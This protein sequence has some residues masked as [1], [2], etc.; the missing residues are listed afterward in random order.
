[1]GNISI[2]WQL[3]IICV[4]LV[5]VP[6]IILGVL[7]FNTSRQTILDNVEDTL[8]IQCIDWSII[9]QSYYD[10]VQESKRAAKATTEGIINS[11][12]SGVSQVIQSHF[13]ED[14]T[15]VALKEPLL[16]ARKNEKSLLTNIFSVK[17]FNRSSKN[18]DSA[19]KDVREIIDE[20]TSKNI[21][22]ET[23]NT[24][25]S[26]Y[27]KKI[28]AL[29]SKESQNVGELEGAITSTGN[30]LQEEFLKL[31]GELSDERLK[32][33]LSSTVIGETGYVYIIDYKGNYMLSKDRKRDGESVWYVEDPDGEFVIQNVVTKGKILG[34][35][36]IDYHTYLWKEKNEFDYREQ[37][38]AI[39]HIPEKEWIV[40]VVIHPDE[41]IELDL[42]EIK[43]QELK[44][45][46]AKQTFGKT[47]NL[48][49]IKADEEKD[50]FIKDIIEDA[51]TLE[52]GKSRIKHYSGRNS[53]LERQEVLAYSFFEPWEWI[54]VASIYLDEFFEDINAVRNKIILICIIA[55]ILGSS[56]VYFMSSLM[57]GTLSQLVGKMGKVAKGDLDVDMEDV[58][59]LGGKN[60]IAQL[61]NAFKKMTDNLR[62]TTFSKDYVDS[63]IG[64]MNDALFVV[65]SDARIIMINEATCRLIGGTDSEILKYPAG[66]FLISGK[67]DFKIFKEKLFKAG[68]IENLEMGLKNKEGRVIPINISGA[69]LKDPDGSM[70]G[71]ILVA[72]D[73][74]EHKKLL[75]ELSTARK[76][77]EEKVERLEKSDKAM[78]F[79]VEDLN[80]T[81]E[82]LKLARNKLEEKIDEVEKINKELD[83]FTYI[84]SHDLKEPLRGVKAFTKLLV[85]DYSPKLDQEAK[86]YITTISDSSSRMSRLIEDLLNLSRIGRIGSV[87]PDVDLNELLSDV[88]KDLAYSL[89]E[90]KV[91]LKLAKEFPKVTCDRVRI[92]EVFTNLIS[93]AI[94]YSKKDVKP[95]IEVGYSKKDKFYEFFVKDNGLGIEKEYY[96]RVFKI[97]QRLHA[98]GEHEGTG[99]GLTI[100]KKIVENHGGSIWV[101]SEVNKGSTFYFTIK[102]E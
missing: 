70:T 66:N 28:N 33:V 35:G 1:M 12:S 30:I 58:S 15:A 14:L 29:K 69:S 84:V 6:V 37:F 92:R 94:K 26:E 21:D 89:E 3:I 39:L 73:I 65:D 93:N 31:S 81:T 96:D 52:R 85:E 56:I 62:N 19:I 23:V 99:A 87:E 34:Q 90:K 48:S 102:K 74:S 20:A 50:L 95:I 63:I 60:E 91:D 8:R 46:M 22:T 40:G 101:E 53:F 24:A 13:K 86:N 43:K 72:R 59:A 27:L 79:M 18:F 98:K 7:S 2:K 42:E 36:E 54:I 17:E 100:V 41:L 9:I 78:L 32:E 57:T 88:K 47:G 49:I 44:D 64:N 83:D 38:I 55:I 77:L 10:L 82:E 76:N 11:Q 75:G 71:A 67:E 25:L 61:A 5:T 68:S 80:K 45:L 4:L 97:F 16:R 51:R